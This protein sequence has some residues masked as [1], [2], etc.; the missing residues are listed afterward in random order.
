MHT[1]IL[2]SIDL[3]DRKL[4]V[5]PLTVVQIQSTIFNVDENT[6][7]MCFSW[8][9]RAKSTGTRFKKGKLY[10]VATCNESGDLDEAFGMG[11]W[12]D[13]FF[14][15]YPVEIK[16]EFEAN[17]LAGTCSDIYNIEGHTIAPIDLY[18]YE[19]HANQELKAKSIGDFLN[20]LDR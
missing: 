2:Y 16:G 12:K 3:I 11:V 6:K 15:D 20:P 5:T 18:L 7:R 14:A 4:A 9:L 17:A 13:H 1:D 19:R 10:R 8:F